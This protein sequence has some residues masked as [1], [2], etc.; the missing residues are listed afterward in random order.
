MATQHVDDGPEVS[1]VFSL[2]LKKKK[3]AERESEQEREMLRHHG[4]PC[5]KCNERRHERTGAAGG[6][7]GRSERA[8]EKGER[9]TAEERGR[10]D[11]DGN[12][13]VEMWSENR[14]QMKSGTESRRAVRSGRD[15]AGC[16]KKVGGSEKWRRERAA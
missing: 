8:R 12:E 14:K 10:R 3:K 1:S 4:N 16:W 11:R 15:G 9:G 2:I 6:R 5:A 7:C 13:K